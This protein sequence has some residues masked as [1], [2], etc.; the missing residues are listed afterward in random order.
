MAQAVP[1]DPRVGS[2]IAGYA[3]ESLLGRGGMG[4]V[5]LARDPW[6]ERRVALKLVVPELSA[7]AR[8]RERFLR[9][10]KLAA[11]LEHANVVPIYEAGEDEGLLY[12]AMRYVEGSDLG[13][14]L[15]ERHRLEPE[16]TLDLLA[17]IAVG[18]DAAHA[19]GLVHRDVKPGNILLATGEPGGEF[20]AVY[21]SD[22]GLS[23]PATDRD[24]EGAVEAEGVVGTLTYVAPEQIEGGEV[25]A[26]TDVYALGCVLYECLVGEVPFAAESRFRLLVAHL[27]EPPPRASEHNEDASGCPPGRGARGCA[28]AAAQL[29]LAR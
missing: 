20:S 17:Q 16:L 21:L 27:Q 8:F 22:F 5:Y 4:V 28:W 24:E 1:A 3:I 7:D 13:V 15:E 9:E 10:S 26:A 25:G 18:L 12:L 23:K 29:D 19:K 2:E 11:S 6:L 14:V